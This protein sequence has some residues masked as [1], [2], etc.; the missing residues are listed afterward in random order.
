MILVYPKSKWHAV[1][2]VILALVVIPGFLTFGHLMMARHD[3]DGLN[4]CARLAGIANCTR[5]HGTYDEIVAD[6]VAWPPVFTEQLAGLT[7][8]LCDMVL[9]EERTD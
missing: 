7:E 2:R 3:L 5:L 9:S 6:C 4:S 1:I 8:R